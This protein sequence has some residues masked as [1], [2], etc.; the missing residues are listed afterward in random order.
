MICNSEIVSSNGWGG[1]IQRRFHKVIQDKEKN[2]SVIDIEDEDLYS[3]RR[4]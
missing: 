3:K 1:E 4:I 2:K